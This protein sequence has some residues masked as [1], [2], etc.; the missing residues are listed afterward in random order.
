MKSD[1][2]AI[3]KR[4]FGGLIERERCP[5]EGLVAIEW[6]MIA[7]VVFTALVVLFAG[8]RPVALGAMVSSRVRALLLTAALWGIY[9]L[10]PCRLTFGV[11]VMMQ[12]VM[13]VWWYPDTYEMN[14][15]F[16]N[17]DHVFASV[18]QGVFGCQPSL[19]FAA[20]WSSPV[21]SELMSLG[22]ASYYPLI[23]LVVF[24]YFF[25]R[26]DEFERC[27]TVVLAAFFVFYAVFILV[28]V[29]GP[30]FYFRAIGVENA[31]AGLFP[32]VG[33]YFMYHQECLPTPGYAEGVFYR[34]VESAKAVGERPTAAFPSSHVG[35]T[36]LLLLLAVHARS[37]L[38][39]AVIVPLYVLMCFATVYIQA[40]YAVDVVAG[41]AAGALL[42]AALMALVRGRGGVTSRRR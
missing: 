19:L 25:R 13:L 40:H 36:T 7:Y 8:E 15:L 4:W 3:M 18:E 26:Y 16:V 11:R 35:I 33:H 22:Y 12:L 23:A 32:S 17:L 20:A 39:V 10:M 5:R 21:F 42:Y 6:V 9:R 31:A 28:P 1:A 24:F 34:L 37:R 41:V 27:V 38:L 2:R 29:V 30:T 14:R